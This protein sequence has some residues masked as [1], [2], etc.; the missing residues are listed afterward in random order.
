M[1]V[2][3]RIL[4]EVDA[5]TPCSVNSSLAEGEQLTLSAPEA[6]LRLT[7]ECRGLTF[8]PK[9]ARRGLQF[10]PAGKKVLILHA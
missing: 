1:P 3:S 5:P 10:S 2:P 7:K 6:A 9:T 8:F 4:P